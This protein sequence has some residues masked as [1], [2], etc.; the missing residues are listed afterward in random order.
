MSGSTSKRVAVVT[1]SARSFPDLTC[2]ID[3]RMLPNR[4]CTCAPSRSDTARPPPRYGT[5]TILMPAIILNS[6][7]ETCS[8]VPLP[9]DA[10]LTLPTFALAY[11]MNF[12]N[13]FGRKRRVNNHDVRHADDPTD[14]CNIPDEIVIE[15]VI[16]RGVDSRARTDQKQRI[17]VR[18]GLC[19]GFHSDIGTGTRS[20]FHDKLLAQTF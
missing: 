10:M 17:A 12:E 9:P 7:P 11:S 1:A 13:R 5:W 8:E 14:R 18:L 6:S 4:T 20:V 19:D 3:V 2:S 16:E 15:F